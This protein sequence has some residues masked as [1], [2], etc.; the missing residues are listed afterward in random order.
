MPVDYA[1]DEPTRRAFSCE[2][3]KP[4]VMPLIVISRVLS[5]LTAAAACRTAAVSTQWH[6]ATESASLC[7]IVGSRRWERA[8][9]AQ[10]GRVTLRRA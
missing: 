8:V 5:F 1:D 7:L 4:G 2:E 10:L 3:L 9:H 6:A